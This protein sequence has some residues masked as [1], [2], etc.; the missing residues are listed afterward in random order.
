MP[1]LILHPGRPDQREVRLTAGATTIGRAEDNDLFLLDGS[2]SRHH[3]RLEL[4]DGRVTLVDLGSTNGTFVEDERIDRREL[5]GGETLRCGSVKLRYVPDRASTDTETRPTSARDIDVDLTRLSM[6]EL[7]QTPWKGSQ[8]AE[9]RLR[10]LLKV[11]QLLASPTSLD[12]LLETVLDLALEILDIDRAA[13][14]MT[15]AETGE[16]APRVVKT[17]PGISAEGAV[18]SRHIVEYVREESVA[19]LF[20]DARADPRLA[21]AESVLHQSICASMCAPLK[22]REEVRGVLYVDNLSTPGRFDQDDLEFLSAFANQAAV[23]LENASLYSELE[24]QAVVRNTLLR[25]FPPA[26]IGRIMEGEDLSLGVRETEV[27]ALFCDISRFTQLS[28]AMP[29]REV[30]SLLNAYF[31]VMAEVVFRHEGT[32]EKYIGDALLAVWGAPFQSPEDPVRAVRAAVEM[33]RALVELNRRLDGAPEL[34]IHIG[35]HTG[36]VA[37]GNVGSDRYVQYATLGEATNLA[38]RICDLAGAAEIYLSEATLERLEGRVEWP[39]ER[40]GA[41][42]VKGRE[43]AIGLYSVAWREAGAGAVACDTVP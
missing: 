28:A 21:P 39:I 34:A 23:A 18:F 7:L 35:V 31:P 5:A 1:R 42:P 33:Q 25:F 11:S 20:G 37:A 8:L 19:A 17:R 3:A 43:E 29:P 10:I 14:L 26:T 24:S 41:R 38:S 4:D 12:R 36:L 2:L 6:Q 16:L 40:L 30:L 15:D 27:T 13:I 9:E 22:L 32:L